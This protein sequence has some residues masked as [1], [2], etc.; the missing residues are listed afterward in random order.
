M[1]KKKPLEN[2]LGGHEKASEY[3]FGLVA[4]IAVFIG[5]F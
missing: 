3:D 4:V 2:V 5:K 1:V